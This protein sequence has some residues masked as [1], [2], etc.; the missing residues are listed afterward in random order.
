MGNARIDICLRVRGVQKLEQVVEE[1]RSIRLWI[2][3]VE[4]PATPI[5]RSFT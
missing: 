4:A 3:K 2:P 1:L 5:V